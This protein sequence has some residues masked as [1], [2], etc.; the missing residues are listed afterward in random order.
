MNDNLWLAAIVLHNEWYGT[1]GWQQRT[2]SNIMY[3]V[4]TNDEYNTVCMYVGKF[5]FIRLTQCCHW[6]LDQ[7]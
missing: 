1:K 6:M 7:S 3:Q 4:F 5:I 2:Y